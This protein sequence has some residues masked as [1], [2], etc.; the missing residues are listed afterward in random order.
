MTVL[1]WQKSS[2]SGDQANCLNLA[3]PTPAGPIHLRES[4]QPDT[5]L[6]TTPAALA[7]LIQALAPN[8]HVRM[9]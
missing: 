2:F 8:S 9:T 5:I 3:A 1:D 7:A 4:D 6:T